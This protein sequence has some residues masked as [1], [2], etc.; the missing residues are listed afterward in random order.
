MFLM[1]VFLPLYDHKRNK[2]FNGK[3]GFWYLTEEVPEQRTK[4][5]DQRGH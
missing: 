5:L 2:Q 3:L 4:I 1:D